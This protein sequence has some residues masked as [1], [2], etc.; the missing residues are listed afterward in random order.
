MRAELAIAAAMLLVVQA[1]PAYAGGHGCGGGGHGG[2]GHGGGGHG[3]GGHG[4]GG[5]GGGGHGHGSTGPDCTRTFEL[6][7]RGCS[8]Y[9]AWAAGTLLPH[10]IFEMGMNVR[11]FGRQLHDAQG[12]VTHGS[13][14]FTYRVVAPVTASRSDVAMTADFRIGLGFP[15]GFYTLLEGEIGGLVSGGQTSVEMTQTGTFG[16]PSLT[17]SQTALLGGYGVV[18]IRAPIL[19]G[20][21]A[22]EMAGGGRALIYSFDSAYHDCNQTT[23]VSTSKVVAEARARAELWASPWVSFGATLGTSVLERGDWMT[24]LYLGIHS[25][26]FGGQR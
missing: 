14:P 3:G 16:A 13:E 10:I 1:A 19:G 6:G 17:S 25:R 22:F 20:T 26:S 15:H 9:G 12:S 2:G 4:G 23:S 8:P 5:H 7:D 11:Q 21:L 24:G 18:G